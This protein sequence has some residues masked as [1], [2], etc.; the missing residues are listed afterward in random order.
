MNIQ[1]MMKQAQKMQKDIMNEKETIDKMIFT[2]S[3]SSVTVSVNGK[4][5]IVKIEISKDMELDKEDIEM[6]EDMIMIATNNALKKVDDET[7]K[8][9]G[10]YGQGLN[11]LL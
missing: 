5:E 11:G 4:K 9:L 1:A 10:K 3:Y 2:E 7:E 8:K 6:L